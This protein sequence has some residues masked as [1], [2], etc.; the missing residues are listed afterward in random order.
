MAK[1][2]DSEAKARWDAA[3]TRQIKMK[4]NLRTDADIL[5][6]LDE[7]RSI[8]GYIKPLI[9]QDIDKNPQAENDNGNG[10]YLGTN[11]RRI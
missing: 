10:S 5:R 3:N 4:L 6:R 2:A 9:R 11:E 8:Q 7:V 1:K